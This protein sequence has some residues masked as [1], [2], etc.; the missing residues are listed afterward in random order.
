MRSMVIS[1]FAVCQTWAQHAIWSRD[2]SN[3]ASV[4]IY[5][6]YVCSSGLKHV[7]HHLTM[8]RRFFCVCALVNRTH[9]VW[10]VSGTVPYGTDEKNTRLREP[11]LWNSCS[12]QGNGQRGGRF[13]SS[14]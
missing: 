9:C 12:Q 8:L 1:L 5:T 3:G 6:E 7:R 10:A 14:L 11:K 4:H 13:A 2:E